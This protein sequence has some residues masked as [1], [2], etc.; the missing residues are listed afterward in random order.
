MIETE[1]IMDGVKEISKVIQS[2]YGIIPADA[3]WLAYRAM[4]S[5]DREVHLEGILVQ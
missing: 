4:Q 3:D 2:V 1:Q 5:I